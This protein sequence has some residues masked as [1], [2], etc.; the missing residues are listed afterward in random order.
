MKEPTDPRNVAIVIISD[1]SG[2]ARSVKSDREVKIFAVSRVDRLLFLWAMSEYT[3]NVRI[4][5]T[6]GVM[7]AGKIAVSLGS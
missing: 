2:S 3:V 1:W 7:Y 5:A 6:T 4:G